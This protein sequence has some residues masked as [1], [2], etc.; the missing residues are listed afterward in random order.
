MQKITPFLWFD[1]QAEQ[2]AKFYVSIFKKG[3]KVTSVMRQ[4][5]KVLSVT[6]RLDGRDYMALNGGPHFRLNEAFSLFVSCKTQREVDALWKKL[7]AGGGEPSMCGW[8]KDKYGLSWQ[9]IPTT[10]M[11]LM[12]DK[13]KRKAQAVVQA[14]LQM[15]KIDIKKLKAAHASA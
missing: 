1:D 13:N 10:L 3:S 4:Q 2:A 7:I 15:Q 9:I 6:F 11:E 5:G 8:L 14:M 12:Q